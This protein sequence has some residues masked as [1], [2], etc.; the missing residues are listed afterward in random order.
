MSKREEP[1]SWP[2]V[3]L[4]WRHFRRALCDVKLAKANLAVSHELH[5]AMLL[6]KKLDA[7]DKEDS[8]P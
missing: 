1:K 5:K 2:E 4:A 6:Q 8:A 3:R 7:I